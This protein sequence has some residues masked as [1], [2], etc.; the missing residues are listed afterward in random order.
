MDQLIQR[1]GDDTKPVDLDEPIGRIS[2]MDAMQQQKMQAATRLAAEL[3]H[4]RVK[5]AL[6]RF[7]NSE[8]GDCQGCG[9]E[10]GIRRLEAQ[11]EAPF[12]LACQSKRERTA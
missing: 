9:E 11:P 10:I 8:Y 1:T 3:R 5:A 4:R 2:R 6:A 12:C 7:E